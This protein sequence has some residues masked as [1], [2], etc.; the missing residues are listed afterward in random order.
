M[1]LKGQ[2]IV[3]GDICFTVETNEITE[4]QKTPN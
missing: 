3:T 2:E 4:K 1:K